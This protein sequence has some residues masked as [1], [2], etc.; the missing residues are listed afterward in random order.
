M[1]FNRKLKQR[2]SELEEQNKKQKEY[3]YNLEKDIEILQFKI[4]NPS[5]F[6]VGDT[7]QSYVITDKYVKKREIIVNEAMI[8]LI[9]AGLLG[10]I[11]LFKKTDQMEKA[12]EL[13]KKDKQPNIYWV[14]TVRNKFNTISELEVTEEFLLTL[15]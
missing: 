14:Y 3:I 5:K 10:Y 13:I 11:S 15:K 7:V 8:D 2:V 4:S 6:N 12:L 1:F 9:T